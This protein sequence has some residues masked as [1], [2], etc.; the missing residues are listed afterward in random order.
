MTWLSCL[1]LSGVSDSFLAGCGSPVGLRQL[2]ATHLSS[3]VK[4]PSHPAPGASQAERVK[5]IDTDRG[6]DSL[7]PW[8]WVLKLFAVKPPLR[9][10]SLGSFKNFSLKKLV[11]IFRV[12]KCFWLGLC[13]WME[14]PHR[15][16]LSHWHWSHVLW[17]SASLTNGICIHLEHGIL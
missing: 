2:E 5:C 9:S 13:E 8:G 12:L 17:I 15:S 14:K 4:P 1:S 7:C 11:S 3:Q 6:L 16:S 10:V